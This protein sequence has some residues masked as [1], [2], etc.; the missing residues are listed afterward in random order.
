MELQPI[1]APNRR[2]AAVSLLRIVAKKKIIAGD[3]LEAA[4]QMKWGLPRGKMESRGTASNPGTPL[5]A[6]SWP[7][8]QLLPK[9]GSRGA[10]CS[11][12]RS[13]HVL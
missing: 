7:T 4:D 2:G 10:A 11:L 13:A 1:A 3:R 12:T 5:I 8:D 9:I 6:G